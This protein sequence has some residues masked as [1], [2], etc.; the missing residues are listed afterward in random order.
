MRILI[1]SFLGIISIFLN[2]EAKDTNFQD[3]DSASFTET[4]IKSHPEVLNLKC[5]TITNPNWTIYPGENQMPLDKIYFSIPPCI[6]DFKVLQTLFLK[7]VFIQ[8]LPVEIELV[9]ELE[10][11]GLCLGPK[12][13]VKKLCQTLKNIEKLKTLNLTG[14]VISD[15]SVS[16]IQKELPKVRVSNLFTIFYERK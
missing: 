11:I 5:V 4:Y 6:K 12:A 1:R 10:N 7:G 15:E 13:D 14:S 9:T 16:V 2:M 8:E 3:F